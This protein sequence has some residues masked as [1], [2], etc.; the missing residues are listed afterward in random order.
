MEADRQ[1]INHENR[2]LN[3]FEKH[4]KQM[5]DVRVRTNQHHNQKMASVNEFR[6]HKNQL[7]NTY[8]ENKTSQI[9]QASE[10]RQNIQIGK[11]MGAV[12]QNEFMM[13]KCFEARRE[14]NDK[15]IEMQHDIHGYEHEAQDLQKME[16]D[17]LVKLQQT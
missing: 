17:L 11:Q 6:H 8:I 3:N 2:S 9:Y 10:Q 14:Q 5:R 13:K 15:A 7:R 12:R 1:R 4:N 16:A